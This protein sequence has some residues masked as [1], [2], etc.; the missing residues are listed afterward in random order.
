MLRGTNS[1]QQRFRLSKPLHCGTCGQSHWR[2]ASC[3]EVDCP[4]YLGGWRTVVGSNSA[5][6]GYIR[7]NS[8][9]AF[10][11][12]KTDDGVSAFVFSAGQRCFR[13]HKMPLD[14]PAHFRH[15]P[16]RA[17]PLKY[18]PTLE[19]PRFTHAYNEEIYKLRQEG[20]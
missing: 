11:E 1:I 14:R 17:T 13:E 7:H 19:G 9:R 20:F 8:N 2:E 18:V 3:A 10:T 12:T 15:Q 16:N 5:Q 6:A 4:H